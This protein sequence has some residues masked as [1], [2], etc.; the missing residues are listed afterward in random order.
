MNAPTKRIVV[1]GGDGIGP[2]VTLA[3]VQVLKDCAA[4]FSH[5]FEFIEMPSGPRVSSIV[6]S[7]SS[8]VAGLSSRA[9]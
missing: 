5:H 8:L 2:E 9:R 7:A 1:L 3:A 4:E 6:W